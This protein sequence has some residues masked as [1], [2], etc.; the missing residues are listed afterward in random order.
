MRPSHPL[1]P[2]T[3]PVQ[4][5]PRQRLHRCREAP[6]GGGYACAKVA[7]N[8]S[9]R[10]SLLASPQAR[11]AAMGDAAIIEDGVDLG[12]SPDATAKAPEGL[13][14]NV[15]EDAADPRSDRRRG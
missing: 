9:V 12:A 14:A 4:L 10:L 1:V 13:P 6:H 2:I 11:W 15:A 3:S 7:P 8:T 5:R